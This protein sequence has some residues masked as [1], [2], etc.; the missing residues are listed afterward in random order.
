ME[1]SAELAMMD[2]RG[3][4]IYAT[5]LP[6]YVL[7]TSTWPIHFIAD[8]R[9]LSVEVHWVRVFLSDCWYIDWCD[10][11]FLSSMW[12]H[13]EPFRL[14]L[15]FLL[16]RRTFSRPSTRMLSQA[17]SSLFPSI[18]A[19]RSSGIRIAVSA[20]V[21]GRT[22]CSLSFR[23]EAQGWSTCPTNPYRRGP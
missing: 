13:S 1:D 6:L 21:F 4:T 3:S 17:F 2:S 18:S 23:G 19:E 12:N 7:S 11:L 16:L 15:H 10:L 14:P 20:G 5:F 8:P 22:L 9:L